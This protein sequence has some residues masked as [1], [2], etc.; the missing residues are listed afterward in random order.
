MLCNLYQQLANVDVVGALD[1]YV[2]KGEWEKC[3]ETAS[4]QVS[5]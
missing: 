4:K 2:E 1:M 3:L 5:V